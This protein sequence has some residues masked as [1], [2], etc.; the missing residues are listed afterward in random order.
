MAFSRKQIQRGDT[1]SVAAGANGSSFLFFPRA[2]RIRRYF[3]VPGVA[4]ASDAAKEAKVEF[5]NRGTNG[6]GATVLATLT[7]LTGAVAGLTLAKAA[8]VAGQGN[9]LD[10]EARPGTPTQAQN[11]TDAI[12]AGSVIEVK[13]TKAALTATGAMVG[14]VE[15]VESD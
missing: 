5:I 4:E 6:A 12:A 13:L 1:P 14:G 10:T 2:V 3:A 8:W 7:N 15:F 9:A 11:S